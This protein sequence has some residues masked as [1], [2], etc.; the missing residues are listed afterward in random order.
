MILK[1]ILVKS[2]SGEPHTINFVFDNKTGV[3]ISCSCRQ[4]TAEQ[5]CKH[6]TA[7]MNGDTTL[8]FD[9]SQNSSWTEIKDL[10]NKSNV[11]DAYHSYL[12]QLQELDRKEDEV[13]SKKKQL[14]ESFAQKVRK[15][16]K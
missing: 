3:N 15:G 4:G 13:K 11:F 8:L 10:F 5:V 12:R 7:V 9:T 16:I 14:K 6:K 1:S 2:D